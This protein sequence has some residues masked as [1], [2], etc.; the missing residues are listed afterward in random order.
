MPRRA[1]AEVGY[2]HYTPKFQSSYS[3]QSMSQLLSE[4]DLLER[5]EFAPY[6]ANRFRRYGSGVILPWKNDG[7]ISWLPAVVD[8]LGRKRAGYSQGDHNPDYAGVRDF[9]SLSEDVRSSPMLLELVREDFSLTFWASH[10]QRLP[11]YVGVHFIKLTSRGAHDP[12][13]S[14]PDCFHQDGEPF[15]FAHLIHRSEGL[16]GGINYIGQ[17]SLRNV[18]MEQA[19]C[20]EIIATFTL[21]KPLESFAV[22]DPKVTHFVS[23]IIRPEGHRSDTC[24]RCM[25]LID[26]SPTVQKI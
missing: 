20:S 19:N 15:T 13:V 25:V 18:P 1:L 21:D 3:T 10:E 26:F 2:A 9:P 14:S 7:E 24:E 23:P 8:A 5:D 22:H 4:F 16:A 17:P 11:I 6:G 12:G